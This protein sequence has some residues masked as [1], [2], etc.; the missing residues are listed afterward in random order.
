[1]ALQTDPGLL[2]DTAEKR[3]ELFEAV[4]QVLKRQADAKNEEEQRADLR[5]QLD[6]W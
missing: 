3:P 6:K 4:V 5:A 1:M 2:E